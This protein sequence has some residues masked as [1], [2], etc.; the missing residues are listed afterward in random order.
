MV[1]RLSDTD[2]NQNELT[3]IPTP[4]NSS[5]AVNKEYADTKVQGVNTS[6]V[7]VSETEP[8]SSVNGDIWINPKGNSLMTQMVD[9]FYPVG[10]L[11]FSNDATDPGILLGVGTW[12]RVQGRFIVGVDDS[13]PDFALNSTG[14][15][16][17]VTLTAAQSGLPA[18]GHSITDPGHIHQQG[19]NLY[20]SGSSTNRY[21]PYSNAADGYTP[22]ESS[23]T[24]ITVNANTATNASQSHENLPPYR[25]K[26]IFERIA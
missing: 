2:Q 24:G 3:N 13:D 25:A 5:D 14:G 20:G 11:W 8:V 16:K 9:F 6:K 15:A 19:R 21:H 1:R 4:Q 7:T 22:T 17:N 26:Y 12:V 23:T 18:H 10:K